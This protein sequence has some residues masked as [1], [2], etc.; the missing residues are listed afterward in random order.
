MVYVDE[1]KA[2][3]SVW[4]DG[5]FYKLHEIGLKGKFW[6]ILKESY[7]NF[8]CEVLVNGKSSKTFNIEKGVHQGTPISMRLYQIYNN[9]LLESL[10]K[11]QASLGIFDI[12]SGNP[13]F[14]DDIAVTS[15]F[16]KTMNHMLCEVDSHG[17]KRRY[18]FNT[19]KSY[20]VCFGNGDKTKN[21]K[22]TLGGSTI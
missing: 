16:V 2:F 5:L 22:I 14:E 10:I 15:L 13:A 9:D 21:S 4:Q 19:N 6:R 12:K 18:K 11:N 7:A 3:D 8:K 20:A 1:A 17:I